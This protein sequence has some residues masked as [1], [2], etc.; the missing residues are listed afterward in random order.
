MSSQALGM[1]PQGLCL[2][3]FDLYNLMQ[4]LGETMLGV[5]VT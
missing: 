3:M 4:T 5:G 1:R 2:W